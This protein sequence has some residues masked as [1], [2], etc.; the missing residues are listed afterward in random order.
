M[1]ITYIFNAKIN[2]KMST[3][4]RTDE[5]VRGQKCFQQ[6]KKVG[7]KIGLEGSVSVHG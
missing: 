6:R 4:K 7:F 5:I 3:Q 1:I 2:I